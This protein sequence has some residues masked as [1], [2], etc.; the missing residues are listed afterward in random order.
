[1]P[2]DLKHFRAVT[3]IAGHSAYVVRLDL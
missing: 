2:A 3:I 1:L